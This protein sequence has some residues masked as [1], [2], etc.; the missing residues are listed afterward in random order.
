MKIGLKLYSTDTMLIPEAGDLKGDFFDF[1]ELYIVPGSHGATIEAWKDLSGSYVVH[2]PHSFHGVNFARADHWETN[3]RC[4]RETQMFADDLSSEVIIVHGGSNGFFQETLR[5]LSLLNDD[6]IFLENKP[7][8]G[9]FGEECVGWSPADF[10]LACTMGAVSGMV[11]D[12]VHANC[13]ALSLNADTTIMLNEFLAF[14]PRVFH[15]SDGDALS[16]KDTHRNFGQGNL[17]VAGFLSLVPC[18]GWITIE[19]PRDPSKGLGDF[20]GDVLFLRDIRSTI[21]PA[22]AIRKR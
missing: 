6:R 21:T 2:A 3:S 12:F 15:L 9:L 4:F 10:L 11:L 5:Q 16:E 14:N 19:T 7:R 8:R 18:G 17:D 20:V 22:R 13:A 1:V